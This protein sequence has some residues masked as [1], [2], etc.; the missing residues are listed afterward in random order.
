MPQ[1]FSR[2]LNLSVMMSAALFITV[3]GV[4]AWFDKSIRVLHMLEAIPYALG[5]WL[6]RRKPKI[7]YALSFASGAFWVWT[8]GFL[9]TFVRNGFERLITLLEGGA[10]DRP[11]MLLAVPAFIGTLGMAVFALAGYLRLAGKRWTDLLWFAGM[12]AGVFLFFVLICAAF[13]PRYLGMFHRIVG[14]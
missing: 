8:A 7:G 11:D 14:T 4:S 5:P 2:A 3:L 6:C 1:N 12:V 13:A 10:I 9:T